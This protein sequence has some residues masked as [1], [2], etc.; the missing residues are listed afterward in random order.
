LCVGGIIIVGAML[1]GYRVREAAP[2]REAV[3][4]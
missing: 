4:E 3:T 2:G 1:K